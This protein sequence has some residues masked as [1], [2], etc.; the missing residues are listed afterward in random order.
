MA[1]RVPKII[2]KID[3]SKSYNNEIFSSWKN[4]NSD[5]EC[6]YWDSIENNLEEFSNFYSINNI[7]IKKE[8]LKWILVYKHGGIY[9]DT[10]T[11]CVSKLDDSLYNHEL[12]FVYNNN[13]K[14]IIS[15]YVFGSM[16]KNQTIKVI[17]DTILGHNV[18]N[19]DFE[20]YID[21]ELSILK[22]IVEK[23][24]ITIIEGYKFLHIHNSNIY[25]GHGKVYGYLDFRTDKKTDIVE[26]LYQL[27][28][29]SISI[30]ICSLN[31]NAKFLKE[32]L[33]SIRE[34][35][36]Y[37]S[38]EIVW[39][40][41]GSDKLHTQILEKLLANFKETTRFINIKYHS[42]SI[43]KGLGYALNLGATMC[44]NELIA[45]M[46]SDDIMISSRLEKQ[47]EYMSKNSNCVLCGC[48]IIPFFSNSNTLLYDQVSDHKD[49]LTWD[50]YKK[51]PQKWIL[52][53]PT[54][55]FKKSAILEVG[56]YNPENS[57]MIDDLDLELRVLKKYGEVHNL[58][59]P[60]LLYRLH[61]NQVTAQERNNPK[62]INKRNELINRMITE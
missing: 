18:N 20:K 41:D 26:K 38:I 15:R 35:T 31:T 37:F 17:I 24:N 36:G 52:N 16:P 44:S 14:G 1:S 42:Y 53:H 32:C 60:L 30:L 57:H 47:I 4:Y 12:F 25:N 29:K 43:A 9:L 7:D 50:M 34:Q 33:N 6:M 10:C 8:V 13:D 58:K 22:D 11:E 59:E 61:N 51:N 46:D 62:W 28:N 3:L 39:I 55:M 5:L 40:N 56:N 27:P 48:N 49:I 21:L 19:L 23:N 54:L 2:H 45:R